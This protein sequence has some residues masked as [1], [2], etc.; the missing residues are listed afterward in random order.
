MLGCRGW[1]SSA[2]FFIVGSFPTQEKKVT[3]CA[4][5]GSLTGPGPLPMLSL[6]PFLPLSSL[7]QAARLMH[8][9]NA[10]TTTAGIFQDFLTLTH[11]LLDSR[12]TPS[13]AAD[14]GHAN[15]LASL[16]GS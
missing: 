12:S 13:E 14:H 15:R 2:N 5:V 8:V 16:A 6:L 11:P 1:N 10:R 7:P 4:E 9:A 3:V